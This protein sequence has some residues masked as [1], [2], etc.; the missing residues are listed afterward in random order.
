MLC[1]L[2]KGPVCKCLSKIL[3]TPG[4]ACSDFHIYQVR[5]TMNSTLTM[6]HLKSVF[7]DGGLVADPHNFFPDNDILHGFQS[8]IS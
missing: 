5:L 1:T 8:V 3:G 2:A 7:P 6:E 4:L